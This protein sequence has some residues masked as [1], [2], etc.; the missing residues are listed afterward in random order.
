MSEK[1]FIDDVKKLRKLAKEHI[2]KGVVTKNYSAKLQAILDILNTSLATENICI[3]RYKNH[4]YKAKALGASVAA[5]EFLEHANQEQE[6]VDVIANRIAQLGGTPNLNPEYMIKHSH[7][8]YVECDTIEEMVYE[9]L[10]AERIAIDIYRR[11]IQFI[12]DSDPTTRR[13]LEDI[14]A[15]EEEHTDDLLELK[16]EYNIDF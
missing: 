7:A 2:N 6:H 14:L 11:S 3:L 15:V 1:L 4:Y 13:I 16:C 12:G 8:D 10:I 5:Q 9:N